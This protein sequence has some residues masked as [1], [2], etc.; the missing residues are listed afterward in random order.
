MTFPPKAPEKKAEK[1]GKK[2]KTV[3]PCHTVKTVKMTLTPGSSCSTQ[4]PERNQVSIALQ[5]EE[6]IALVA[7]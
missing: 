4:L 6:V 5:V 2:S 7:A 3:K 1:K